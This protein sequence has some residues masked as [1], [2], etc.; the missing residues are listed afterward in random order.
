[1]NNYFN[2]KIKVPFLDIYSINKEF[3]NEFSSD[4]IRVLNSGSLILSSEVETFEEEFANYCGTRYCI[5]VANGLQALEIIMRSLGIREGDEVIVPSNT[6]IAT[7]LAISNVGAVPIPVEP[8]LENYNINPDLIEEKISKKTKAII[9][10]H[11]YGSICEMNKIQEIA[12]IYSLKIIEDAAQSHGAEYQ[13]KKAGSL[14]DA[15]AFSFYPSKNL[16]A[17]GDGGAITTDDFELYLNARLLRNYGSSKKYVNQIQGMNSRLDE[18]QAAFLRTK[19][20]K[21]DVENRKRRDIA[22]KYI[23]ELSNEKSINIPK[24]YNHSSHVFHLF[25]I[26]HPQRE[27]FMK[28]LSKLGVETSM[29]YPIPP[30]FQP[31]YSYL[32][33]IEGS[34]PISELI[35]KE[36]IS[37]PIYPTM[38]EEQINHVLSSIKLTAK[39]LI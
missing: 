17:L 3:T 20:K 33:L 5:G 35:H 36:C 23:K 24:I 15:A 13:S 22:L 6:Y 14:G 39:R 32:N 34:L 27:D 9:A 37:L 12:K 4:L 30:H 31:A 19:L 11:L 18:L 7:W 10:V 29:H 21:L 8:D 26:R 2:N 16:G 25:V 38:N 28:S 1:M